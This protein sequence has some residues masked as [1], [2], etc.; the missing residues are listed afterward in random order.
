MIQSVFHD[1][2]PKQSINP[3]SANNTT[4]NGTVIDVAG[5]E[6]VAFL[7]AAGAI[8]AAVTF[9]V[10]TGT[11]SDG[12][13]MADVTG[14]SQAYTATDDNKVT[15]LDLKQPQKRYARAVAVLGNGTAQLVEATAILYG[16]KQIP[17]AQ[18]FG[19]VFKA[20]V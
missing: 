10:Q 16:G 14:L 8:D 11:Q 12:S 9:K 15:V 1:L 17:E 4:L 20:G 6:G 7:C 3:Q 2:K 13:D 18:D 19:S 5:Y